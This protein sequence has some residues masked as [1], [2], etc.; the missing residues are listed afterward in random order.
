MVPLKAP[1]LGPPCMAAPVI[2]RAGWRGHCEGTSRNSA[3]LLCQQR[4]EIL[5]FKGDPCVAL[6]TPELPASC[7]SLSPVLA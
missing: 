7:S 5:S 4:E 1:A 3:G 2:P 6:A